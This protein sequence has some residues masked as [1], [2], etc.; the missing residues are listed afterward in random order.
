[1]HVVENL[2]M[3]GNIHKNDFTVYLDFIFVYSLHVGQNF[4][5]ATVRIVI[6]PILNI[7]YQIGNMPF[8]KCTLQKL[9]LESNVYSMKTDLHGLEVFIIH[10][11]V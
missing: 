7:F 9:S 4:D 6:Q 2:Q 11:C 3:C 5:N 10:T 8:L 1:M